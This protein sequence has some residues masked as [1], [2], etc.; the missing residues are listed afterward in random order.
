MRNWL[1]N[2][3]KRSRRTPKR[4]AAASSLSNTCGGEVCCIYKVQTFSKLKKYF[5]ALLWAAV[6]AVLSLGPAPNLPQSDLL[7]PDKAAHTFVYGLL[8]YLALRAL[9]FKQK[10][11]VSLVVTVILASTAYGFF[12]E[13]M[14]KTFFPYRYFEWGDVIAN[15]AGSVAGYVIFNRINKKSNARTWCFQIR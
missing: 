1:H 6:I 15:A 8:V 9:H 2:L 3:K 12:L 5:P 10:L 14:Q 11:T 13:V 7:A 4:K